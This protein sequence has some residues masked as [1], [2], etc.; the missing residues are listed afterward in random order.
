MEMLGVKVDLV[1]IRRLKIH[2]GEQLGEAKENFKALTGRTFKD[3]PKLFKEIFDERGESYPRTAKGNPSFKSE[4]LEK[5]D[6]PASKSINQVRYHEKRIN[7]Y[8][9]N[10]EELSDHRGIIHPNMN[11]A[12]TVTGR[13]SYS[14]PNLQNVP[15][16]SIIRNC[17][18]TR[19]KEKRQLI[20]IDYRAIEYRLLAD[21]ANEK[22]LIEAINGGEDVHQATAD[23]LKISRREAKT[24][25]FGILYGCGDKTLAAMLNIPVPSAYVMKMEYFNKLPKI[26]KFI[27]AVKRKGSVDQYVTN[28]M[29]R[30]LH[31]NNYG[32]EYKLVNYLIQGSAADV[33]KKAM[34][35]LNEL[36]LTD[37]MCLQVHDSLMFDMPNDF[38]YLDAI[39]KVMEESYDSFFGVKL[40]V[41]VERGVSWGS[42]KEL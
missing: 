18:I 14:N 31:I 22:Y 35:Q 7:T 15:K 32:E 25:N 36:G 24:V 34:V 28:W 40:K 23:L 1:K 10:F 17:F 6:T 16:D 39:T 19:D 2:E 4:V 29:G 3:S 11:Q 20:D 9:D 38:R 8:Y 33:I 21:Y 5:M 37:G 27:E 13:F 30:K 26:K 12:G 42:M 41:S